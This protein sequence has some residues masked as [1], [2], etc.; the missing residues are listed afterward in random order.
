MD[1]Y[2]IPNPKKALGNTSTSLT[3]QTEVDLLRSEL[4]KD[5]WVLKGKR[6]PIGRSHDS[7][8]RNG[9]G[10]AFSALKKGG[11]SRFRPL[12]SFLFFTCSWKFASKLIFSVQ[13]KGTV[14]TFC[15]N[16]KTKGLAPVPSFRSLSRE[17]SKSCGSK[18]IL[19]PI[20][21]LG[22]WQ[23]SDHEMKSSSEG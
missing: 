10:A 20:A 15:L 7:D 4:L 9:L 16:C 21:C 13:L 1:V 18:T 11:I 6:V 3:L 8:R 23:N 5:K 2:M 22:S 14:M 12:F 17:E 19:S